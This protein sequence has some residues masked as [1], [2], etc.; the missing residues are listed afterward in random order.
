MIH[1]NEQLQK[2][3]FNKR[4]I[5]ERVNEW[6]KCDM[7]I[8]FT[9]GCFDLLHLGHLVYLMEAADLGDK[10]IIGLNSDTS[11]KR[12]KGQNRPVNNQKE[13][14]MFLSSLFYVDAVCVFE[15][16]TPIKL[17]KKIKPDVLVKGGDYMQ[18]EIIGHEIVSD[19]GGVIKILNFQKDYS[20][21][22]LIARIKNIS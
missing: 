9:N 17:I 3:L 13:R 8:V 14:V 11:V 6:K 18:K 10:L 20:T 7:K 21:T 1:L 16:N 15:E 12:L 19:Y 4:S 22:S 5:K 2:K